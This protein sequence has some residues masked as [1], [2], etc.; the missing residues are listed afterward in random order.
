MAIAEA[1][2]MGLLVV[3]T[4]VGGVPEVRATLRRGEGPVPVVPSQGCSA[5]QRALATATNA[6]HMPG[7][8]P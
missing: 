5:S 7:A 2:S 1:A 4:R 3:S 6:H 8:A